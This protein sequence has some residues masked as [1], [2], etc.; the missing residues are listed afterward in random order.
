MSKQ[1][2]T[3]QDL[4]SS[5]ALRSVAT[6]VTLT[7]HMWGA[8]AKDNAAASSLAHMKKAKQDDVTVVTKRLLAGA[9]KEY[10]ALVSKIREAKAAHDRLTLPYRKG[11]SLLANQR[12]WEYTETMSKYKQEIRKLRNEFEAAYPE[13]IKKAQ[14]TL[15]PEL[16]DPTKYPPADVVGAAFGI[17]VEFT[18]VPDADGFNAL[19]DAFSEMLVKQLNTAVIE[20]INAA[21]ADGWQR[22]EHYLSHVATTLSNPDTKR[23]HKSMLTN[24]KETAELIEPF[25]ITGDPAYENIV[26][27]AK[28]LGSE[29]IDRI[30]NSERSKQDVADAAKVL[31]EHM[32]QHGFTSDTSDTSTEVDVPVESTEE[33]AAD[34][35]VPMEATEE[36][37]VA[38]GILT[39]SSDVEFVPYEAQEEAQEEAIPPL[40][41]EDNAEDNELEQLL[42]KAGLLGADE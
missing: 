39:P 16:A 35:V 13:A 38:L 4:S 8:R 6:V 32:E 17:N 22:L 31:L 37:S 10:K 14:D 3:T 27:S 2:V 19:P 15:G 36:G 12:V 28:I 23:L 20:R 42:R 40:T 41:D 21:M 34:V 11:E 25:N 24:V 18:P 26:N 33:Q 1:F 7:T 29:R 9:D 5:T 30:R